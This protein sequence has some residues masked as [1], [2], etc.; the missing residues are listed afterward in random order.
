[1]ILNN[2]TAYQFIPRLILP[3]SKVGSLTINNHTVLHNHTN[4]H[5]ANDVSTGAR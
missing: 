3:A 4:K 1:M 2:L 5:K